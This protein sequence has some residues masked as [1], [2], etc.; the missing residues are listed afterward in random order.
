MNIEAEQKKSLN[1]LYRLRL[2]C[3]GAIQL[4][5]CLVHR[6]GHIP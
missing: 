5:I 3:G 2:V 6:L 1:R 4:V